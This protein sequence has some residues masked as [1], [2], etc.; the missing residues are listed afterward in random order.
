MKA[1]NYTLNY[2]T[3]KGTT[4]MYTDDSSTEM[5]ITIVLNKNNTY[6]KTT[7]VKSTGKKES[8]SGTFSIGTFSNLGKYYDGKPC[9]KF[10]GNYAYMITKNNTLEEMAGAGARYTYQGN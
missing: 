5:D 2:G 1:G 9:I 8:K 7:V 6:T 3:Y 10:D 4:Y